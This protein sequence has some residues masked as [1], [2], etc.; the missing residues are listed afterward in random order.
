MKLV[1]MQVGLTMNPELHMKQVHWFLILY[2]MHFGV[3]LC[4]LKK[5]ILTHHLKHLISGRLFQ[6]LI[7]NKGVYLWDS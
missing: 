7:F 3:Q 4:L 1:K 2:L 5:L 6:L